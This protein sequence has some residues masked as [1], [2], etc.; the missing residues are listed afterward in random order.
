M[1]EVSGKVRPA[2]RTRSITQL[3]LIMNVA[4]T[5]I[6]ARFV[7]IIVHI[8]RFTCITRDN[9]KLTLKRLSTL[10]MLGTVWAKCQRN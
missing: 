6:L 1:E 5:G 3:L 7:T 9:L 8:N 2:G 4:T 10:G